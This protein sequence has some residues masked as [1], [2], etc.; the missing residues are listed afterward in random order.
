M[1]LFDAFFDDEYK[2]FIGRQERMLMEYAE[3]DEIAV[4][5]ENFSISD[6]DDIL[7][8]FFEY[9]CGMQLASAFRQGYISYGSALLTKTDDSEIALP[10]YQ[11]QQRACRHYP[12]GCDIIKC[13]S[14][15]D[16]QR[17][18]EQYGRYREVGYDLLSVVAYP[19]YRHCD[20][21]YHTPQCI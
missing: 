14:R 7:K 20:N 2:S 10:R 8:A 16:I 19:A 3:L 11:E 1:E 4:L 17:C 18:G 5:I 9:F 13:N 6:I 15:H 21:K 12:S